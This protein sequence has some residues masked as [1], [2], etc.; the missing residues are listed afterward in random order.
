MCYPERPQTGAEGGCH[1]DDSCSRNVV[2]HDTSLLFI[3]HSRRYS[4]TDCLWF[5]FGNRAFLFL[6]SFGVLQGETPL[7]ENLLRGLASHKSR[8]TLRAGRRGQFLPAD[9]HRGYHPF[10]SF[11]GRVGLL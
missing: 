10:Q 11:G 6:A 1:R 7:A 8:H 2:L 9:C 3:G 4:W 5:P